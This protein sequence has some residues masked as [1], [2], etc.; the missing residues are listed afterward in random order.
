MP[1]LSAPVPAQAM[2]PA[3]NIPSLAVGGRDA[4]GLLSDPPCSRDGQ[5]RMAVEMQNANWAQARARKDAALVHPHDEE[6]RHQHV[7]DA[8]DTYFANLPKYD[9]YGPF[10]D[11]PDLREARWRLVRA[12][13]DATRMHPHNKEAIHQHIEDA[14]RYYFAHLPDSDVWGPSSDPPELREARWRQH[15]GIPS[16]GDITIAVHDGMQ[17]AANRNMLFLGQGGMEPVNSG[18]RKAEGGSDEGRPPGKA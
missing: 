17:G 13:K 11:P 15:Y 1:S 2:A 10:S 5:R 14:M 4:W 6:A 3:A 12:R 7:N 9:A 8:M 16:V 18:K